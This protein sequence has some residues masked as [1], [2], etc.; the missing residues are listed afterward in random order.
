MT[1]ESTK[2]PHYNIIKT[3]TKH[4]TVSLK[5]TN[6]AESCV[7]YR[8]LHSEWAEFLQHFGAG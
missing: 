8:L 5:M 1:L 7:G 3:K 4:F 6:L 2:E